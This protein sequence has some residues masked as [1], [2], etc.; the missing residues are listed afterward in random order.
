MATTKAAAKTK[1][2]AIVFLNRA[3][4]RVVLKD[5]LKKAGFHNVRAPETVDACLAELA[6]FSRPLLVLDWEW[7][8]QTVVRVLKAVQRSNI[9]ETPPVYLLANEMSAEAI[10]TATEYGVWK[11]HVGQLSRATVSA[12]LSEIKKLMEHP[13]AVHTALLDAVKKRDEGHVQQAEEGLRLLA[14]KFPEDDRVAIELTA[15]YIAAEKWSEALDVVSGLAVLDRMNLRAQNLYARCLMKAG[16]FDK[17]IE[18]LQK[19]KLI[20]PLQVERLVELGHCLLKVDRVREALDNFQAALKIEPSSRAAKM[21]EG[22]CRMIEGEVNEGLELVRGVSTPQELASI[23][24]QAGIISMRQKKF[25]TGL[26]LYQ[27]AIGVLGK[28]HPQA[29]ARLVFNIGI[30]Y[31]RWNNLAKAR[32]F[33]EKARSLDADFKKAAVNAKILSAVVARGAVNV[34]S[35]ETFEESLGTIDFEEEAVGL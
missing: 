21:G 5:E 24:N 30:G 14:S 1:Q 32:E 23:F 8:V 18:I 22:V 28:E 20:N 29:L 10:A 17:A 12:H 25:E 13:D 19:A 15:T 31:F 7:G 4:L 6:G 9:Y 26:R 3:P 33:F 34:R 16:H 2:E 35:I 11:I 27:T